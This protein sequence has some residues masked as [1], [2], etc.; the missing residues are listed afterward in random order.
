MIG[1]FIAAGAALAFTI[2]GIA[3]PLILIVA[4]KCGD[5]TPT[6]QNVIVCGVVAVVAIVA[7]QLFWN[8]HLS[9][10]AA[11]VR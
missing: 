1:S 4:W 5:R 3:L 7:G 9:L 2:A 10:L 8:A 6:R 11:A